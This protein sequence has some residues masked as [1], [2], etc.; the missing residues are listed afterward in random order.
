[1]VMCQAPR[2]LHT[3]QSSP[4]A[5]APSIPVHTFLPILPSLLPSSLPYAIFVL[6]PSFS[7]TASL[8]DIF[9][10]SGY[11]PHIP[12]TSS[13]PP[14]LHAVLL[15]FLAVPLYLD[16]P[17]GHVLPPHTPNTSLAALFS[18]RGAPYFLP[19]SSCTFYLVGAQTCC[20][21][22]LTSSFS[23]PVSPS[24]YNGGPGGRTIH[25]CD[26]CGCLFSP[27]SSQ[28]MPGYRAW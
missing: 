25:T 24:A 6:N 16:S 3:S 15:P 5:P 28:C 19:P 23:P 12:Y 26:T 14:S 11:F 4:P 17:V 18:H 20:P 2:N 22:P 7:P 1:M 27:L 21:L 13:S 8:R 10:P 9:V